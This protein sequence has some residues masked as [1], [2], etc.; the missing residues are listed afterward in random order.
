MIQQVTAFARDHGDEFIELV[1]KSN[2][3]SVEREIH[4]SKKE[5]EQAQAR[6]SK[7]D[8]IIQRLYEDN[9][10]GR[11]SLQSVW[12]SWSISSMQPER[13][14]P[15]QTVSFDWLRP[16]QISRNLTLRSS[17]LLL[18]RYMF[19]ERKALGQEHQKAKGNFQL[20]W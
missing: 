10:E 5:F 4:E 11:I 2:A 15:M 7:L 6:I 18:R 16:T 9:I 17:E 8:T 19:T 14:L 20:H 1:T 13:N 3:K 12:Q